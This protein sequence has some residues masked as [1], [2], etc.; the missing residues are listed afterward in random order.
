MSDLVYK[1]DGGFGN[2]LIQLTS[3]QK[4]CTQ[5]HD[6]VFEYELGNCITINGFTRVSHEGQKPEC[7]IYI[8]P[9][10]YNVVHPRIRNIIKPTP[11]MEDMISK[12]NHL[13]EDV[14]C[15]MSIRRGSYS[16]DSKQFKT[17]QAEDASHY[18]C[19]DTGV[20]KFINIIEKSPGPVFVSSDSKELMKMLVSKFGDKIRYY[21]SPY[22]IGM[23]Q[24]LRDISMSE[25][26]GIYLKF[27]LLSKCPKLYLT[28]GRGDF[29]GFSTYGYMAAVY[30][31]KPFE[32]IFN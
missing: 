7:P 19:S 9:Y 22:A 4:E 26:H 24:D 8:N 32:V 23:S 13:I 30:G 20:E 12:Y 17:K 21:D 27:F 3:L 25:Y 1:Q 16:L 11:F 15:G 5:V 2:T 14:T 18:F 6:H 29:V 28:G 31:N 10:T